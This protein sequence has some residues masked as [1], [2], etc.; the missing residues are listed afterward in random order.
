MHG[1]SIFKVNS[2]SY[3][4]SMGWYVLPGILEEISFYISL[5]YFVKSAGV[6]QSV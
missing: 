1:P 6:T 2:H 5:F 3:V 4:S